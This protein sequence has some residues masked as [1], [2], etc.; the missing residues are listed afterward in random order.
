MN[1]QP[2]G[3]LARFLAP[4]TSLVT[5]L[6]AAGVVAA[7]SRTATPVSGYD[8][9]TTLV[10]RVST[11]IEPVDTMLIGDIPASTVTL[12][13]S[14]LPPTKTGSGT[15]VAPVTFYPC[16]W[17]SGT[18]HDCRAR[19]GLIAL[20]EV[21]VN[22]A[23]RTVVDPLH[24][25]EIFTRKRVPRIDYQYVAS[26]PPAVLDHDLEWTV[27]T[28]GQ[29]PKQGCSVG[30]SRHLSL[31][32]R[33]LA[34]SDLNGRVG[35]VDGMVPL[36][37]I[38][39]DGRTTGGTFALRTQMWEVLSDSVRTRSLKD[40]ND[41][42][43]LPTD[44]V[45]TVRGELIPVSDYRARNLPTDDIRGFHRAGFAQATW[46]RPA[47]DEPPNTVPAGTAL[48]PGTCATPDAACDMRTT[49]IFACDQNVDC[50][51]HP[52]QPLPAAFVIFS[53]VNPG[54]PYDFDAGDNSLAKGN[55]GVR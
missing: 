38:R 35:E 17:V 3:V 25:W 50:I 19:S 16:F 49:E 31:T 30:T 7:Q 39:N 23:N 43:V 41:P 55:L 22:A 51:L 2:H 44:Q 42:A 28:C 48:Q 52:N 13:W 14:Q 40:I 11:P 27:M 15:A 1:I 24:G 33:D 26:L 37:K 5:L 18:E 54:L 6:L 53:V 36:V 20:L 4:V 32:A 8:F 21:P 10:P 12:K 34:V 29:T 47:V 45:V 9:G 46:S